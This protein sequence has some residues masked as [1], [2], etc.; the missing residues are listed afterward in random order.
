MRFL[1]LAAEVLVQF[2]L[3]VVG[4]LA[5]H[6]AELGV[7]HT[8]DELGDEVDILFHM[9]RFDGFHGVVAVMDGS[10]VGGAARQKLMAGIPLSA[11]GVESE[12]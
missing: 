10:G 4:H 8:A 9:L 7:G 11:N 1:S 5:F 3:H 12:E 2:L 6:R